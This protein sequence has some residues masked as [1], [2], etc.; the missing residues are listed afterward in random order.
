[1]YLRNVFLALIM[2][3]VAVPSIA[4]AFLCTYRLVTYLGT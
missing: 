1:M 4:F 2:V 3:V